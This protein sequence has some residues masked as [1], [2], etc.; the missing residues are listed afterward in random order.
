MVAQTET[1]ILFGDLIKFTD[2]SSIFKYTNLAVVP[3]YP[4]FLT[5]TMGS[6]ALIHYRK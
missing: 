4:G 6:K 5:F 3:T 1:P 2:M